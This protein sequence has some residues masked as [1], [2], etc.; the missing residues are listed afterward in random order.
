MA[1]T[2]EE[3]FKVPR[4]VILTLIAAFVIMA[5]FALIASENPDGLERMFETI[6]VEGAE[7]GGFLSFGEGFAADLL[8]MAVGMAIVFAIII[9]I[10]LAVR[11][12]KR[13]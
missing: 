7:G 9:V 8:T 4:Y 13:S 5:V 1:S 12:L 3:G 6:G 11:Y 10:M 2:T